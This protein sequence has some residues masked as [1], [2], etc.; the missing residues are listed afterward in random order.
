MVKRFDEFFT[1]VHETPCHAGIIRSMSKWA[2][3]AQ[4]AQPRLR[5]QITLGERIKDQE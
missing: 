1:F 3:D 5:V 2:F 4:A